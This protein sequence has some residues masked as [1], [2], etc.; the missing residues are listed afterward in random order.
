[1][2]APGRNDACP[3]GSGKKYKKCCQRKI[4]EQSRA[5]Y[6]SQ[7]TGFFAPNPPIN[8]A[9]LILDEIN[10]LVTLFNSGRY[11]ELENRTHMLVDTYPNAGFAW[12]FL[13]VALLVQ[14]K[15][16]LRAL[17]KA[18]E[19]LPDDFEVHNNLGI[20]LKNIGQFEDSVRSFHCAL[21]INPDFAEAHNNLGGTL[22]DLGQFEDAVAS[23]RHA[24]EVKPDYADAHFNLGN[25]LRK[26][27]QLEDA[28]TS[29]RRALKIDPDHFKAHNNLGSVLCDLGQLADAIKSYGLALAIKSDYSEAHNN[30]GAALHNLGQLEEAVTSYHH[31]VEA[32]PDYADAHFNLGNALRELGQLEDAVASYH[33]ALE[34]KSDYAEAYTNLGTALRD[35]GKLEEA[36]ASYRRALDFKSEYAEAHNNLGNTL[37][38]LGQ[39]ENA[40]ACYRRAL[41]IKPDYVDAYTA[42]LFCL[43]HS[44]EMDAQSLFAEHCNFGGRFE[45][46]LRASW[47]QHRNS[48]DTERCLQVGFVSGDLHNH[49]VA[50]FIEP[51]L[52]HLKGHPK[53]SLHGYYNNTI[54]DS[55][56]QRLRGYLKHWHKISTLSDETLA[57]K[58]QEDG[59]DILIDL[60]GH[61]ALNR[62]LTFARKPAPIQVS[63]MGYPG[64]TGL[65]SIDYYLSDRFFTPQGQLDN[66]FMEKIVC[67]PAG[68]PFLPS[69]EAPKVNG[70]PALTNGYVTFGS[71]N[72]LSKLNHSVI[73]LWSQLLRTLP[74]SRMLLGGMPEEGNYDVLIEWFAQEGIKRERLDFY[75]RG[76]MRSYLTLHH[77]VDICLDTFPYNGGT[78]TFHAL[79]MGAPTLTLAGRSAAGRC[80][81]AILSKI[82]ME[83]F[84]AYDEREFLQ[85]GLYWSSNLV[86]LAK[87]R[88]VIRTRFMGSAISNPELIAAG[89]ERALHIMWQHWCEGQLPESFEVTSN[90]L[91]KS[92]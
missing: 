49:A 92:I 33:R 10:Q 31:A 56:T 62:L 22:S 67:L 2:A 28:V 84:I 26:L 80:G 29:Y 72:R 3:C 9:L 38:E 55:V 52:A 65:T 12:K 47:P 70:L 34:I 32:K 25:D 13:G 59:I 48:R 51:I 90:E 83:Q 11:L 57:H 75:P 77:Q 78:T 19:L 79:W 15:D 87:I 16:A 40:V 17:Q 43:S 64:T 6:L 73:A 20:A 1:M 71:F 91:V 58:I 46:P 39:L 24:L 14:G 60:S 30:L 50:S 36:E 68:A 27:G 42:L 7:Q 82:G 23:Y 81:V 74:D 41:E 63:W 45:A 89:L 5:Q 8:N 4:E 35:M 18:A 66:Q 44:K 53:L 61:T 85:H 37:R 86:E 88:S 54:E 76:D 21:L 69:S